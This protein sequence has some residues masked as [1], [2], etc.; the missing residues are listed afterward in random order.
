MKKIF[1]VTFL[2]IGFFVAFPTT[3]HALTGNPKACESP[4]DIPNI[5]RDNYAPDNACNI[6]R[7]A[8]PEIDCCMNYC[9]E[10]PSTRYNAA[11]DCAS[12]NEAACEAASVFSSLNIFGTR[13]QYT[14]DKIPS[15][16][17]LAISA[18]LAVVSF[19]ALFRG[20]FLY[21]IKRPNT[22]DAAEVAKINK[23]FGNIIVGFVL[24]WSV[25]FIVEFV[26]RLLGLPSLSQINVNTLDDPANP[27]SNV[28]IIQ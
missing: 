15:L 18:A 2:V 11:G 13:I 3:T 20:M 27:G 28:I 5:C 21:A 25:I 24:A 10:F 19:Y 23:E 16:I 17:Q 6:A 7:I 9:P 22:T 8:N 1:L 26:M 12:G 14:P 4:G